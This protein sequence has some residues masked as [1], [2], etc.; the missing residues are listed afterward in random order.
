MV[1]RKSNSDEPHQPTEEEFEELVAATLKVDPAGLSG[2]H[3][4]QTPEDA[5]VA[6]QI[7]QVLQAKGCDDAYIDRWWREFAYEE[8]GDMTPDQAW[9]RGEY[10]KILA[11]AESLPSR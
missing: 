6:D 10:T 7:R 8:L 4:K 5:R 11:L 1:S 2:K 9:N 3:R